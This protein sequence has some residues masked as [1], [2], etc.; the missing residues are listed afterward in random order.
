MAI[1]ISLSKFVNLESEIWQVAAV[2]R[3]A[4]PEGENGYENQDIGHFDIVPGSRSNSRSRSD[5]RLQSQQ[6]PAIHGTNA[7][8]MEV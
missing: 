3:S 8:R 6:H 4:S 7:R 2:M 1:I 5:S